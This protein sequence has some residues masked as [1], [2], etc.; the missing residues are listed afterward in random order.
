MLTEE[1]MLWWEH[2]HREV[3]HTAGPRAEMVFS[4]FAEIRMHRSAKKAD[5]QRI[6][7]VFTEVCLSYMY[8]PKERDIHN[9]ANAIVEK[10]STPNPSPQKAE[11]FSLVHST[12]LE[13]L[14]TE[15]KEEE[16]AWGDY[17]INTLAARISRLSVPSALTTEDRAHI[18]S[19]IC[20]FGTREKAAI[21]CSE[22]PEAQTYAKWAETLQR[23]LT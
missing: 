4:A 9:G 21:R 14:A 1:E 13:V 15:D 3:P 12:L 22:G 10:L 8:D 7:E 16:M 17:L 19:M 2:F 23:L 11:V 6:K 18:A 20:E 5:A